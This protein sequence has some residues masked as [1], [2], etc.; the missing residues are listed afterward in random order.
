M[1]FLSGGRVHIPGG[2]TGGSLL[3]Q[4]ISMRSKKQI[5][6][7]KVRST[8]ICK[9]TLAVLLPLLLLFTIF[10]LTNK[11]ALAES[12]TILCKPYIPG[13]H[14]NSNYSG[15]HR[16]DEYKSF[17]IIIDFV[18][19]LY[20][21]EAFLIGDSGWFSPTR[22]AHADDLSIMLTYSNWTEDKNGKNLEY[23]I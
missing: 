1:A 22:Y 21:H 12:T 23:S 17:R 3:M 9:M 8:T 5:L 4:Q 19:Q 15:Y 13:K 7:E 14:F 20:Q 16:L 11:Q 2:M 18:E 6:T 10:V